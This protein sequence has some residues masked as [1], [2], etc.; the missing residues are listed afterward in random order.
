MEFLRPTTYVRQLLAGQYNVFLAVDGRDG[1][2]KA[3]HY[4]PD[5]ILSDQM[6]PQMSGRTLL[7]A[8]RDDAILRPT[9][10]IFL[11]ARAGTEARVESLD[12]S[13]DDYL[14]K[15][16][17]EQELLARIRNLLHA[18]SQVPRFNDRQNHAVNMQAHQ[19]R[20]T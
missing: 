11:T 8:I 14:A 1:L 2:E 15:P 4:R 16:F 3:R 20:L 9:P 12:A 10:V 13:A 5:L 18:R 6:M 17:D 19:S 7:A